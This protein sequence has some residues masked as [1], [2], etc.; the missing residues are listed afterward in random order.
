M[1]DPTTNGVTEGFGLMFYNARFY[2]PYI[3]H[4]TQPDTI[5]PN[6]SSPQS[7]DR[8]SYVTNNPLRYI[9]PSGHSRLRKE[10]EFRQTTERNQC[11]GGNKLHCSYAENHPGETAAFLG[12]SL[13]LA[14]AGAAAVGST[15]VTTGSFVTTGTTIEAVNTACGGDMC[16][17]EMDELPRFFYSGGTQLQAEALAKAQNG[18]T[19]TQ[20]EIGAELNQ[21]INTLGY[22]K[23][24]PIIESAS[25][26]WAQEASG[27]VQAVLRLP[28]APGNI[29][30]NI[31]YPALLLNKAVTTIIINIIE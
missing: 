8:Y 26:K 23:A 7:W 24:R 5:I 30:G 27:P 1:D 20:T 6:P 3:N 2:S 15:T 29:W 16:A 14:G 17:G 31:E 25:A 11:R 13:L 21:L 22:D 19:I 9:D 28:L 10:N 18:V 4:F 12:G